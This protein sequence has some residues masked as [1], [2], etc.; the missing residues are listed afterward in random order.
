MLKADAWRL[1]D[2]RI[3]PVGLH[4]AQAPFLWWVSIFL[5]GAFN[6]PSYAPGFEPGDRLRRT[7]GRCLAL[8]RPTD[9]SS[10]TPQRTGPIPLVG[11]H[12][13]FPWGAL[14]LERAL[15][16]RRAVKR[17]LS[18]RIQRAL[19]ARFSEP[20][21]RV[22]TPHPQTAARALEYVK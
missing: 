19:Y 9:Y 5:V 18:Y 3:T 10:R 15:P 20:E 14:P 12:L 22:L 21:A 11:L 13:L 4:S 7:Q 8:G 16:P 2:R 17:A 6:E 1:V